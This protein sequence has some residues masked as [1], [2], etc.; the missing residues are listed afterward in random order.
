VIEPS[1]I[2]A[3]IQQALD[4]KLPYDLITSISY[5]DM[6]AMLVEI[7]ITNF[8]QYGKRMEE[9]RL[10]NRGVERRQASNQ[11]YLELLK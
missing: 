5:P 8:Q 11:D 4:A 10:G 9:E 7:W 3:R 1:P 2:L 6:Y